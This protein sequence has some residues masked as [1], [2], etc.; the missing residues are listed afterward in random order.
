LLVLLVIGFG[1]P[2]ANDALAQEAIDTVALAKDI[3]ANLRSAERN[4]FNGK[5]EDADQQL[6]SVS[7]QIEDLR[8]ADPENSKLGS[9][10]SKYGRIR[11]NLDRKLGVNTAAKVPAVPPVP[12]RPAVPSAPPQPVAAPAP[13]DAAAAAPEAPGAPE[14]PRAVQSD[15]SN[16][17]AKLD[18]AEAKWAEDYTGGSTVGGST[19]PDAVKLDAVE[20]PLNS[21][22]FYY[23][24][25]LKKC[26]RQSSPCDP[27]HPEIAALN[28]RLTAMQANVDGL[29]EQLAAAD[30]ATAAAAA[31]AEAQAQAAEAD[32]EAWQERMYVYTDGDKAL[33]RCVSASAEDM[34]DCKSQYDE[35]LA[36][37]D[38]FG[39][40]P[41]ADEPCG[42]IRSTLSDLERYMENFASS[43]EVYAAEHAAA[44]ANLGEIVFSKQPIDPGDPL[45]LVKQFTAGDH[46]YGLIRTTKPWSEIYEGKASADVM[47]N[48]KLDGEKIHAQFVKLKSPE[49]MSQRHL[50]FEIA[51]DPDAMTAYSNP[52][53]VYGSST[54]TMRQGP[55][56]LT[57]HLSKLGPGEHEMSLDINYFGTT[58]AA[59]SFTISG[60]DFASYAGLHEQIA[61]GVAQSVTL[62]P[63]QMINK[64]MT[65]EMRALLEN[66]GWEDIHRIN[67][68]D[69]DWWIDRVSG[70]NS[71]VQSRHVAAAAL[72]RDGDGYFYKVCTFHQDKLLTGGFGEL[73]LSHQGDRVPMPAANIDK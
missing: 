72:A 25:I 47:V 45:D 1:M 27:E 4:M 32:C 10:E 63:A 55:H 20:Q 21:A 23:G 33:Y 5:N 11:K 39:E 52:D 64:A 60:D 31:E 26:Q 7:Q 28:S 49:L 61:E 41:W 58:W 15:L 57:H 68:V 16:A 13:P 40:T 2:E 70:G 9:L 35:A 46:I 36:L 53:R 3:D 6:Q 44:I 59:G 12:P 43:Y 30:A 29:E 65:A 73:Y 14:L 62:P 38:E 56:E 48:V 66:A 34:P 69:K 18:E 51:P 71:P 67:I 54:A 17:R 19:D 37:M 22:N 50:A 24:N 42:A 8:S